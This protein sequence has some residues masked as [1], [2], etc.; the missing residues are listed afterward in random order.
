MKVYFNDKS[1]S[2]SDITGNDLLISFSKTLKTTNSIFGRFGLYG[3]LDTIHEELYNGISI[4]TLMKSCSDREARGILLSNIH[5]YSK[6]EDENDIHDC[7]VSVSLHSK[8][9]YRNSEIQVN[10][11]II[12]NVPCFESG[13]ISDLISRG[14]FFYKYHEYNFYLEDPLP[15]KFSS[16]FYSEYFHELFSAFVREKS[17]EKRAVITNIS[18]IIATINGFRKDLSLCKKNVGKQIHSKPDSKY[19]LSTDFFHGTFEV[20]NLKGQH[21]KE[22]NYKGDETKGQDNTGKHD[23]IV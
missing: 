17:D 4:G 2:G 1:I 21:V 7:V 15:S 6:L 11:L 14:S 3:N 12:S 23:I 20:M 16:L 10:S 5:S 9:M 18:E 8:P 13:S 22:L 19:I